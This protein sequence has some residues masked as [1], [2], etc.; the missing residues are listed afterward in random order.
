MRDV[1]GNAE[2]GSFA[3]SK[4]V[5]DLVFRSM[6]RCLF[7]AQQL[8]QCLLRLH[9][10]LDIKRDG[11]ESDSFY[12]WLDPND[13]K[14]T[15]T[16]FAELRKRKSLPESVK[17]AIITGINER[18][19]FIHSYWS[20]QRMKNLSSKSGTETLLSDINRR[21]TAIKKAYDLVNDM[22]EKLLEERTDLPDD[23]PEELLEAIVNKLD[24][25]ARAKSIKKKR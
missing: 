9:V 6:G 10:Q 13:S 22:L 4:D 21:D 5:S 1:I 20:Y 3:K 7:I 17:I 24:E 11:D 15:G 14:T 19:S 25:E 18:N 23:I 12:D 16:L 2:D 8:E